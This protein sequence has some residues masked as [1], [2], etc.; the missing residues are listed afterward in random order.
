VPQLPPTRVSSD[1]T[2]VIPL[3]AMQVTVFPN[4]GICIGITFCHVAADG[5]ALHHFMKSWA[6]ICRT[7][8]DL[9]CLDRSP[10][11]HDRAVIKDPNGLEH[12]FLEDW[13]NWGSAW[14][15]DKDLMIKEIGEKVRATFVLGRAHIEG[16][17]QWVRGHCMNKEDLEPLHVSTFV[18]ICALIWVCL[19]KSQESGVTNFSVNSELC[20]FAFL[21]DCRNR[22]KFPIP[23]TYFGN[24]LAI[25]IVPIEGCELVGETGI[26]EAVKAIGNKVRQLETEALRGAETWLS[27]WKEKSGPVNIVTVAGSPR[28]GVY[29]TDFGWGRPKKSEVVH[30]DDTGVISLAECRDE[31]GAIEVGLALSR[32]NIG[33]FTAI[34]EQSLKLF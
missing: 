9:S 6:S 19:I 12:I 7:G 24:C 5:R 21:A 4:E 34:W 1:N 18:V 31:D 13:W 26:F 2:R 17:K 28:F 27:E 15:D 22:L 11:F 23:S 20:Y 3:M 30:I 10:P 29:E 25:C 16:L 8:G 32:R 33:D 14:K